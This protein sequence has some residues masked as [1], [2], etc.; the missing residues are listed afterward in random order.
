MNETAE[1]EALAHILWDKE[2]EEY[3]VRIPPQEVSK[4]A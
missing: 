4:A 3:V 2:S 1:F